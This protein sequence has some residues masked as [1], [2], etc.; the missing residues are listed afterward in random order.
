M[1]FDMDVSINVLRSIINDAYSKYANGLNRSIAV[2]VVVV[3]VC[4]FFLHV[5]LSFVPVPK[6]LRV[7]DIFQMTSIG[8]CNIVVT[9]TV[10][11][12]CRTS[13]WTIW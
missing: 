6:K 12:D 13:L 8:I 7:I 1:I 10:I 11:C 3:G 5:L 4:S 2:V 9:A